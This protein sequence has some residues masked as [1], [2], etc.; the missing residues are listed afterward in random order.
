M[1]S[2]SSPSKVE[3]KWP[4]V[5]VEGPL[6]DQRVHA[7][8][9]APP[10]VGAVVPPDRGGDAGEPVAGRPA[11]HAREGVH[12][13]HG[14]QL[15][16]AGVGLVEHLR[17]ARPEPLQVLEQGGVRRA[18]QAAVEEGVGGGEHHRAVGVV[19]DLRVGRVA[20]PHRPHAP[21]ARKRGG[22]ALLQVGAAGDAV[23]RRQVAGRAVGVGLVDDVGDVGEV[24]LH[25]LGGAE[26]V[27]R[28]DHEVGVAQPAEAV[29]P[30]ALRARR[31]R[32]GGGE[33]GDDRPR[34]L[35]VAQL[36]GD[37]GA[38]HRVLP[39]EGDREAAHPG[40]PVI[41]R[42]VQELAGGAVGLGGHRLVG[43]EE[44]GQA[45][46]RPRRAA[47]PRRRRPGRRW[48]GAATGSGRRSAGGS[49]PASSAGRP[50]PTRRRAAGAPGCADGR[51]PPA[52]A[53]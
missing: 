19:L 21:V 46:G 8:G 51:A 23:E 40:A 39:V 31:L 3:T 37:R 47:P 41:H 4:S 15:P 43:A 30:V 36:Q 7:R 16:G 14:A 5:R 27:Q 18:D 1:A 48:S 49:S 33:R 44:E 32:H 20:D 13:G 45:A 35:V 10:M 29:V 38:D 24:L 50:R 17:R 34:L 11:H 12:G 22:E 42:L 52:R 26:A 6:V 25:G 9:L 2:R 53:G 28:L